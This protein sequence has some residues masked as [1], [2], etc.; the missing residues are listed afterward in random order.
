MHGIRSAIKWALILVV[1]FTSVGFAGPSAMAAKPGDVDASGK[2]DLAD[3]IAALK[4]LANVIPSPGADKS[5]DINGDA[6]IGSQ[7]AAYALQV[8]AGLK[9]LD[10]IWEVYTTPDQQSEVGPEYW[11]LTVA[12][13]TISGRSVCSDPSLTGTRNGDSITLTMLTEDETVTLAGQISGLTITGTYA[14]SSSGQTLETGTWRA[15]RS[16]ASQCIL[17]LWVSTQ[18]FYPS[19]SYSLGITLE[20][21]DVS[22]ISTVSVTGP[23]VAYTFQSTPDHWVAMLSAR[24]VIGAAYTI[25]ITYNDSSFEDRQW[26]VTAINDTFAVITFPS[27]PAVQTTT[28][29]FTWQPAANADFYWIQVQTS[30]GQSVWSAHVAPSATSILFNED[31]TATGPLQNG[32]SYT[33][34]LNSIDGQ[35]NQAGSYVAF[36]VQVD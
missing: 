29:T 23:S 12:D 4:V 1:A 19:D 26:Q 30:T 17:S 5:A 6:Q 24:P 35:G 28:P 13:T 9:G 16:A 22:T 21:I 27:G 15:N 32:Q 10:G 36:T 7:E 14:V 11:D 25:R 18:H 20:N 34:Y 33:V 31:G 3:A 8:A 2:V